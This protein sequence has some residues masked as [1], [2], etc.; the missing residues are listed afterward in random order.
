MAG[1]APQDPADAV[2]T[3]PENA[4]AVAAAT[5]GA[6]GAATVTAP[7]GGSS[8]AGM[9]VTGAVTMFGPRLF[10]PGQVVAER[11]RI[12]RFI[13]RGGMGEVYEAQDLELGDHLAIKVMLPVPGED[14]GKRADRLKRELLM[15]RRVTHPNV[16]RVFD[17][18]WATIGAGGD[19]GYAVAFVTMELLTGDTLHDLLRRKGRLTPAEI[20][21]LIEQI[22]AALEAAHDASVI[23]RDLKPSNVVLVPIDG[24][25]TPRVV[26]TDFGLARA[27]A[28]EQVGLSTTDFGGTPAYMAPEQVLGAPVSPA[29]DVFALGVVMFELVT[30]RLPFTA[31]TAMAMAVQRLRVVAPSARA[32][33]P[34]LEPRWDDVIRRCLEREP[35]RRFVRTIDVVRALR[36]E[37]SARRSR[38]GLIAVALGGVAAVA[39]GGIGWQVRRGVPLAS[40]A[41]EVRD[42]VPPAPVPVAEIAAPTWTFTVGDAGSTI[43]ERA[44]RLEDGGLLIAGHATEP[45][46]LGNVRFP[47]VSGVRSGFLARLS[48]RGVVVWRRVVGGAEETKLSAFAR[49]GHG[50]V[51]VVGAHRSRIDLGGGRILPP[52]GAVDY[53]DCYAASFDER[54]G[55]ARWAHACRASRGGLAQ[56]VTAD[57]DGNVYVAGEFLGAATFGGPVHRIDAEGRGIFV[58]SYRRDG[59]VRWVEAATEAA[60]DAAA[61]ALAIHG[62]Q[63]VVTGYVEGRLRFRDRVLASAGNRDI[64]TGALDTETGRWRWLRTLGGTS[65]DEATVV[66][67]GPRGELAIGGEFCDTVDLPGGPRTAESGADAILVTLDPATGTPIRAWTGAGGDFDTVRDLAFG[68][69]GLLVA[70]RYDYWF[71]FGAHRIESR[72]HVDGFLAEIDPHGE[73]TWLAGFGGYGDDRPRTISLDSGGTI[74]MNGRFRMEME[75]FGRHIRTR[76]NSDGFVT[77]IPWPPPPSATFTPTVAP[78]PPGSGGGRRRSADDA[79]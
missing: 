39:A 60:K 51:T 59:T 19:D 18:D 66:A 79:D 27:V 3:V 57:A 62:D 35:G 69:R 2:P 41:R 45:F 54:D 5:P 7:G 33:V 13:A 76:G 47:I 75:M 72:G 61:F 24:R 34:E 43:V 70:G 40:V 22:V 64:L 58:A 67:V 74:L 9:V 1:R 14:P 63:V 48:P 32:I 42:A 78:P 11:Y 46:A 55:A 30:G 16:C 15:A 50:A 29:T 25:D 31:E 21:P 38:P 53:L 73:V 56:G 65:R 4:G 49:D 20:L 23:H 52:S 77:R 8:R 68:P 28:S 6:P 26:V 37:L 44:L 12:V 36:G 10:A 17:V 71:R